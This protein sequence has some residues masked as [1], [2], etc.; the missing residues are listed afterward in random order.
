[1][2]KLLWFIATVAFAQSWVYNPITSQLEYLGPGVVRG[3]SSLT[4]VGSVPYVASAGTLASSDT[5][6][7]STASGISAA[8]LIDGAS[9]STQPNLIGKWST[10]NV[11][12]QLGATSDSVAA[13]QVMPAAGASIFHNARVAG[14][15]QVGAV[16]SAP[17]AFVAGGTERARID[18]SGRL[19]VGTNN[20]N[21]PVEIASGAS[22]AATVR[23]TAPSSNGNGP[24]IL[25]HSN[26][27]G[28]VGQLQLDLSGN[29]VFRQNQG[30]MYFDYYSSVYFRNSAFATKAL[31]TYD[32]N[33][34]IGTTT[35]GGYKLDVSGTGSN[36][37]LRVYDATLSSGSTKAVIRAGAG[38]SGNLLEVQNNAG[39]VT[40]RNIGGAWET[41]SYL[42]IA[43]SSAFSSYYNAVDT[44]GF[45]MALDRGVYYS[46]T[47]DTSGTKDLHIYRS[48]ANVLG[49]GSGS[50][51]TGGGLLIEALKSTT[52]TRYVCV[53][54]TGRFTSSA[55]A[56]SGT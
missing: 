44:T 18:T 3:S 40:A 49:I 35:D 2:K 52:G 1:M 21:N 42:A 47:T 32:G 23:L 26:S 53:D 30:S 31:L 54:T 41:S 10:G 6:M 11:K 37:T 22:D 17:L 9:Q 12:W 36:G 4:T 8:S 7:F 38:Q 50:G 33:L 39:T 5:F 15:W 16:E 43:K 29:Y 48:A 27:G 46:S 25:F 19:G 20:P 51:T 13:M 28:N 14:V 34:L 24:G 45:V 55:T 56:C